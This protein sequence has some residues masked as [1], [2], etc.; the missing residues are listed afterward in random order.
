[1]KLRNVFQHFW[2]AD[3][4]GGDNFGAGPQHNRVVGAVGSGDVEH[5]AVFGAHAFGMA[6]RDRREQQ[7][8]RRRHGESLLVNSALAQ[9]HR[10]SAVEQR[11]HRGAPL[12][13]RRRGEDCRHARFSRA[14]T[15]GRRNGG[16]VLGG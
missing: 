5:V 7:E 14:R 11:V 10:L 16:T 12:L 3:L 9:Q 1:M 15:S 2:P 8:T 6:V 13:E 4:N